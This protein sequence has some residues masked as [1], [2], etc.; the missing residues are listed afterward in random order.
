MCVPVQNE[1]DVG[2]SPPFFLLFSRASERKNVT[3]LVL[4]LYCRGGRMLVYVLH[5]F[6]I[7]PCYTICNGYNINLCVYTLNF[8]WW[9]PTTAPE[10]NSNTSA[11]ILRTLN[12]RVVFKF[13]VPITTFFDYK[14]NVVNLTNVLNN[15]LSIRDMKLAAC[16]VI[17]LTW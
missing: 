5:R 15:Y 1:I 7:K 13:I 11:T 4:P 10:A 3:P 16:P 9:F 2:F 17:H 6:R 14:Y 8:S 12:T